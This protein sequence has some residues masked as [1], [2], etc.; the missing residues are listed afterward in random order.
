MPPEK[1]VDDVA[2]EMSDVIHKYIE[3]DMITVDFFAVFRHCLII[4]NIYEAL[5]VKA[6]LMT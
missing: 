4:E 1:F 3:E 6:E 5:F 2:K